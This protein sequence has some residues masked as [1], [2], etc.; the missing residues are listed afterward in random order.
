MNLCSDGH[1]EI[2][3]E[4]YDCPVCQAQLEILDL[5]GQIDTLKER[6]QELKDQ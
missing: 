4:V 5:Q 1:E 3:Y 2:C 6:L